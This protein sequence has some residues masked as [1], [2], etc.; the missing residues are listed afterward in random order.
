MTAALCFL[1][2][3]LRPRPQRVEVREISYRRGGETLPATLYRP[4]AHRAPLP[5]WVVLHGLTYT[6]RHHPSLQRFARALAASG[7]AILVPEIPEWRALRVAPA[8]TGP[9][10]DGAVEALLTNRIAPPERISVLGFSF[11]ATQALATLGDAHFRER[12]RA[13]VAWG[14]YCD[15]HHL[16]RF[17]ITGRYELDG[18]EAHATPDPYGTWI[19]GANFLTLMPG[20]ERYTALAE[21]LGRLAEESGR[22]GAAAV[23]AIYDPLKARLRQDLPAPQRELFDLVAPP[24]ARWPSDSPRATEFANA[25]ADAALASDPCLDPRPALPTLAARTLIAHG[26]DD[27]LIPYT[28][29]LRLHRALPTTCPATCTI[30]SLFAHSGGATRALAPLHHAREAVRFFALLRRM[31]AHA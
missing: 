15:L 19:M 16:F 21:A 18:V 20:H 6:G 11:G 27:H 2:D 23:D 28:E 10:I 31:L 5:S 29:S 3:Y 30:T 12:I 26:R 13:V 22:Q 8:P 1:R 9:S 7:V 4:A 24:A 14:G 25:L 17:G